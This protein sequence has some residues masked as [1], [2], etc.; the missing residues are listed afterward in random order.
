MKTVTKY[1]LL[2]VDVSCE[3]DA[4][5]IVR[6][7]EFAYDDVDG[8]IESAEVVDVRDDIPADDW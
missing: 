7:A 5:E 6:K 3:D 1:V 2:K 8:A 4:D